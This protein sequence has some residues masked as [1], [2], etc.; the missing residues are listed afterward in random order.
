MLKIKITLFI[1]TTFTSFAAIADC[2]DPPDMKVNWD[3]CDKTAAQLSKANL[4]GAV[5]KKTKLTENC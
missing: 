4:R 1:L 3:S 5:L 2:S